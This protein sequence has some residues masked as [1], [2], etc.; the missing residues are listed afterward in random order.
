MAHWIKIQWAFFVL[1]LDTW[2]L[3]ESGHLPLHTQLMLQP[4]GDKISAPSGNKMTSQSRKMMPQNY[5]P[6]IAS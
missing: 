1:S 6:R 5:Y 4:G 3:A 2:S